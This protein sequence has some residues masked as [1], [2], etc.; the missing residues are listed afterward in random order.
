MIGLWRRLTGP[1]REFGP[2]AGMIYALDRVLKRLSPRLGLGYYE[3]VMQPVPDQPLLGPERARQL[4]VELIGRGHPALSM[5][6]VPAFVIESR[7]AQGAECLGVW[8][9]DSLLG[10][11]WFCFGQYE[12]DEVRCTYVLADPESSAFDFDLYVLPDH[13]MGIGFMAVW[14]A[15]NEYLRQRGIRATF[16]RITRFNLAS[17]RAHARLGARRIGRMGF[18]R[19]WGVEVILAGVSPGFALTWPGRRGPRL[20]MSARPA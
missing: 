3:L 9:R 15:A 5:M 16:S 20:H 11:V 10:Y 13:R 12:E 14:H 2:R 1:F 6:P 7:F 19:L 8:R 18:L 17:R 4:R